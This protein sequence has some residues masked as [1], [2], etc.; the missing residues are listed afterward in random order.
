[1]R[2][3]AAQITDFTDGEIAFGGNRR[4]SFLQGNQCAVEESYEFTLRP[5]QL[6]TIGRYLFEN[7]FF[8]ARKAITPWLGRPEFAL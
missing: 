6:Q 8:S 5:V 3:Y 2:L 7:S 1:M 4:K